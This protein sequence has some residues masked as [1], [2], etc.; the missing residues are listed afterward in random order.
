MMKIKL[1][2]RGLDDSGRLLKNFGAVRWTYNQVV[3]AKKNAVIRTRKEATLDPKTGKPISW[4]KFLRHEFVAL[5]SPAV[6]DNPW[7]KDVGYDIRDGAVV[8]FLTAEATA[9]RRKQEGAIQTF[10]MSFKSK[11]N[12][13]SESLYFRARWIEVHDNH[14]VLKWPNQDPMTLWTGKNNFKGKIVMDCRI[15]RLST[16]DYYLCI[17]QTYEPK[18]RTPNA[19]APENQGPVALKVCSLDPGVRTF[20]TIY[21]P[22]RSRVIEV[23][24]G[25][26]SRLFRICKELDKLMSRIDTC[27]KSKRKCNMRRA[28]KRLR[29]RIKSLVREVHCQLSVFLTREYDIIMLPKF[30]VSQMV[31]KSSRKIGSNSTRSMLTWS[32]FHFRERLAFKCRERGSKLVVVNEAWTSKTCS[33]C[34]KVKHDLG[35]AKVFHCEHCSSTFD[36]DVNGAKNIF[37]KN[38]EALGLDFSSPGF[39]AY[40]LHGGNS[41]VHGISNGFAN[42]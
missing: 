19:A 6:T 21:D 40:P 32:H 14:V 10:D 13:R 26:K 3:A 31:T 33:N 11:K 1:H 22:S 35:K 28:A 29:L 5:D 38:Y 24:P 41:M 34:G 12:L 18:D 20:Q 37:L 4:K 16:N 15:Q 17:P 23:A 39:G 30:E 2:P 7:L 27:K 8:D 25:D 36:R 42:T 9:L